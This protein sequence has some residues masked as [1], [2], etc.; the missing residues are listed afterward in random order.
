MKIGIDARLF[1]PKHAGIGRYT[2]ELISHLEKTDTLNQYYIFLQKD[3]FDDYITANKNFTKILADFK[4]YSWKEHILF[5]LLLKKIKLDFV[6]FLHFNAP[7]FYRKKFIITIHD[8][9]ISHYP[10]SRATTLNPLIYSLK[11]LIYRLVVKSA[12]RRAKKI[13]AVSQG[14]KEDII[15]LL[16]IKGKKIEVVYEGVGMS[17]TNVYAENH[18]ELNKFIL[19]VGSAYPHKNLENLVLAFEKLILKNINVKLVLVGK[20]NFFYKRLKEF[21][22]G[23]NNVKLN[24]NIVFTGYLSDNELLTLYKKAIAYAYPSL[25]EG[26][27]LPPLEAQRNG[28]AVVASEISA[29]KEILGS[30]A[31]FFNPYN[32]EDINDKLDQILNNSQ[33]REDLV[34]KGYQNVKKYSWNET[35]T[36]VVKL[37][38]T[39]K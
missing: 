4:A 13:I 8:L 5:P 38:Q 36:R 24:K 1:G 10:S 16:K 28:V 33:K 19:Y 31:L 12:S 39:I 26:F 37:Y 25:I 23:L 11:L 21:I 3:C 27:G 22:I 18:T 9:I 15:K 32:I 35:A 29:L 14:T 20:D 6:H 2:Q 34:Q 17:N 30:S 7:L